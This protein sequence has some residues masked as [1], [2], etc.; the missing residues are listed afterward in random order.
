MFGLAFPAVGGQ[1]DIPLGRDESEATALGHLL[2]PLAEEQDGGPHTPQIV[3]LA[4]DQSQLFQP[5]KEPF[6]RTGARADTH[7]RRQGLVHRE[8]QGPAGGGQNLQ[9]QPLPLPVGKERRIAGRGRRGQGEAFRRA[10]GF[11]R[12]ACCG[13]R[14]AVG[15]GLMAMFFGPLLAASSFLTADC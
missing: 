3:D 7:R 4:R 14:L 9:G 5:G 6:E 2:T 10:I 11:Q 8:A 13:W 1:K 12:A 15:C